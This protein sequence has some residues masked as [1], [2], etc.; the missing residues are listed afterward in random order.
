MKLLLDT[1]V[2][3]WMALDPQ[4][5]QEP[6]RQALED[7]SN[8]LFVSAASIWEMAIKIQL[9]KLTLPT[10]LP[11]FVAAQSGPEVAKV[12][13]VDAEHA[14]AVAGLPMH[15]R[16]PFDRMLIAQ[17]KYEGLTVVTADEALRAYG[18]PL[19]WAI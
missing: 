15:H 8:D 16:D 10:A 12:L 9:G 13:S 11:E 17:A 1:H 18:V 4:R 6:V 2:W 19:L 5:L 14:L 3:L 7:A